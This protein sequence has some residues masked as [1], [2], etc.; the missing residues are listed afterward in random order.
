MLFASVNLTA[1]V[2]NRERARIFLA[3]DFDEEVACAE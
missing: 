2:L 3:S 1:P